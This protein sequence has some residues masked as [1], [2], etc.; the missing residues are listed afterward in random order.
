MLKN[1]LVSIIVPIYN[2]EK[3]VEACISSLIE[4]TY[5]KIEII[6][7]NDG[8]TDGSLEVCR[9]WEKKDSRIRLYSNPNYGV[10]YTRNYAIHK[11]EGEFIVFVD[12][13]DIVSENYIATL[14]SL[15]KTDNV[16]IASTSYVC[17]Y[18]E[19]KLKF[20]ICKGKKIVGRDIEC[21][22][23]NLTTGMICGK[24]YRSK[25]IKEYNIV[26]D[27]NIAVME[28][29]LFNF[30][31]ARYCQQ[32][33]YNNSS[34]YGYRQRKNSSI[35]NTFSKKWFS[36]LIV[37]KY[38]FENYK[39]CTVYPKIIFYY[40]K[41]LYEADFII[42]HKKQFAG[43]VNIDIKNEKKEVEKEKHLVGVQGRIKLFICKYFF[44]AINI[45]RR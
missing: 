27:E 23:Y 8:S 3:Y 40:L 21:A 7:V 35:H 39:N 32:L 37:Y 2:S 28:D 38:L 6:L 30:Q 24:I 17:F 15:I 34:L 44:W 45:V 9:K 43:Y 42:K 18:N 41:N 1:H 33:A 25:I 5:K 4:Q 36:G 11:S 26:F 12:S 16:E 20:N 10:S 22:F 14:I 13:D 31:Y 19:R 29:L